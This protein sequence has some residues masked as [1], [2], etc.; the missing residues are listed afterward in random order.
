[1]FDEVWECGVGGG[2]A[3]GWLGPVDTKVTTP[4]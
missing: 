1:M 4:V 3:V 2:L